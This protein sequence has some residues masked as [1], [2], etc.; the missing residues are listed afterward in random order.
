[1]E[2]LLFKPTLKEMFALNVHKVREV[3][4]TPDITVIPNAGEGIIGI[5]SIRGSIMPVLDLATKLNLVDSENSDNK[6]SFC[7]IVEC[8][9]KTVGLLVR[10]V[11]KI[12]TVESS[13]LLDAS[14]CDSNNSYIE[15]ILKL[16]DDKLVSVLDI[17]DLFINTWGEDP[18]ESI[19]KIENIEF[20]E[21]HILC[22]DDSLVARKSLTNTLV[23]LGFKVDVLSSAKEAMSKAEHSEGMLKDKYVAWLIDAEMPGMDGFEL[24]LKLKT[25]PNAVGLPLIILTSMSGD[26]VTEKS[27]RS[28]AEACLIKFD[29]QTLTSKLKKWLK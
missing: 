6:N 21:R 27:L 15:A 7:I 10:E 19:I 22:V 23:A 2:L 24:M 20:E 12:I 18:C 16:K 4:A 26:A 3:L 13:E 17:E 14:L 28:G 29:V 1:M 8:L 11:H 25:L 9:Q 5:M